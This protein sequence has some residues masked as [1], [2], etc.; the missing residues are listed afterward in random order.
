MNQI[1]RYQIVG[2][3][4]G[5]GMALVYHAYDP[6]FKRDVAIKVIAARFS[7]EPQFRQRFERE[8][9]VI[10]SLQHPAI[11]PVYDFGEENGQPFL[12]MALMQGGSLTSGLRNG[13]L[14]LQESIELLEKLA[15]ALD[16]A[17]RNGVVHRDLKPDN[18]LFDHEGYP[19]I[20][21]FGIAK[22]LAQTSM[23][24][25]HTG[26]VIGTSYYMSTEQARGDKQIDGRS[27]IYSLGVILFQLLT[28]QLP[29]YADTA[30][31]Y[32]Y[33]HI[34]EP[35]PNICAVKPDLPAGCEALIKRAM[36]KDPNDRYA[37][38]GE[39][40]AAWQAV[41]QGKAVSSHDSQSYAPTVV[42]GQPNKHEAPTVVRNSSRA[43]RRVDDRNR[44]TPALVV[45]PTRP[46]WQ[47]WA[48]FA[49]AATFLL[50]V[51]GVVILTISISGRAQNEVVTSTNIVH[52][53][54]SSPAPAGPNTAPN[55]PTA[56]PTSTPIAINVGDYVRVREVE[57]YIGLNLRDAPS[58]ESTITQG[59]EPGSLLEVIESAPDLWWRVRSPFTGQEGWITS[60]FDGQN[61]VE[62][63]AISIPPAI[64]IGSYV[65]I[66][67]V[68]GYSS[69]N[70]RE[71]PNTDSS[72]IQSLP[73]GTV[74]EVISGPQ[75]LWWEV[76][77]PDGQE[78]WLVTHSF[79]G[80]L[81]LEPAPRPENLELDETSQAASTATLQPGNTPEALPTATLQPSNTPEA[82]PT[83]TL[84]PSNTPEAAPAATPVAINVG[85]Y[86]RVREIEGYTGLNLRDAPTLESTTI[87][88]LE[89]GS[90]LEA[91]ERGPDLWW[92]VRSPFTGQ[93]G[94][95]TSLF[96]A[97]NFVEPVAIS[98]PPAIEIGTYVLIAEVDGYSGLNLRQSPSSES[99][100]IE[101]LPFGTV[102][103]VISGP[104]G[105]WWEV[106]LPD[107]QE[108][109]L[110]T[111][112]F[113]GALNLEPAPEQ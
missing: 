47:K 44:P 89:P 93:E 62:P 5:G 36:A 40:A 71:S 110:V 66:A 42:E 82:L 63:V 7:Q 49:G 70:L 104:Q 64:Q 108:G 87:Q 79:E 68:D 103:E 8:A 81:N 98:I 35:V 15:P 30:A 17:H 67:E 46:W 100:V 105:L 74:A 61:F 48:L 94:W 73:F 11:V 10:A 3:L 26:M 95:I 18:I 107:G 28:G 69:L 22:L 113:K 23:G 72:I 4:G 43:R 50:I 97:Q 20:A 31:G 80:A 54:T 52:P 96:D 99:S 27:D 91:I 1:G 24:L 2:E 84:Q 12:V 21:D 53:S 58:L 76:R 86:L 38:V 57:G 33:K 92:R 34:H 111:F 78:G 60:H 9:Q 75:G 25:S 90:L 29:Y 32:I 14:S 6:H 88:G 51:I 101:L 59:L 85:D 19:Y 55:T 16:M 109:W 13:P 41:A 39:M 37:T 112:S 45:V 77:L 65:R 83:A 102:A 56:G 106:R